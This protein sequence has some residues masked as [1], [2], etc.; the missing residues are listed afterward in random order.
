[1]DTLTATSVSSRPWVLQFLRNLFGSN[2]HVMQE[3]QRPNEEANDKVNVKSELLDSPLPDN[4]L[5][6]TLLGK[7]PDTT[8]TT[9]S[10][11]I[12]EGLM[13]GCPEELSLLKEI[14][15][16]DTTPINENKQSILFN[17][18]GTEMGD[19]DGFADSVISNL[20]Q[21]PCENVP[22]IGEK[23]EKSGDRGTLGKDGFPQ[24]LCAD[25]GIA[26]AAGSMTDVKGCSAEEEREHLLKEDVR[27]EPAK[28]ELSPW[29]RLLNMYKQRRRL[30]ASK[31]LHEDIPV[32][33]VIEDEATLDL[34]IYG[35]ATP[36]PHVILS[37]SLVC[38]LSEYEDGAVAGDCEMTLRGPGRN[39][40][41]SL[42]HPKNVY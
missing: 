39:D 17:S 38:G 15:L 11:E 25:D 19:S 21:G 31:V 5:E 41:D 14:S 37:N 42:E 26:M 35:T 20:A 13:G 4:G 9:S 40:V 30:P 18:T 28:A 33:P 36:K 2:R 6:T 10:S 8:T 32:Q 29:N 24:V 7:E 12:C 16:G 27:E 3:D 34:M 23:K 22:V 1:M